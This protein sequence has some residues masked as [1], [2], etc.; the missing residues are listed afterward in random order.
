MPIA[1]YEWDMNEVTV[2]MQDKSIYEIITLYREQESI[3][4]AK[5]L[6]YMQSVKDKSEATKERLDKEIEHLFNEKCVI[7]VRIADEMSK[8]GK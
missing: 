3:I 8:A 5:A 4:A 1:I 2:K 7:A 6:E